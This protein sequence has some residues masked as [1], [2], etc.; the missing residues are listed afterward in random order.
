MKCVSLQR[1]RLT[2]RTTRT[3]SQA[4]RTKKYVCKYLCSW[5]IVRLV[6][7]CFTSCTGRTGRTSRTI[8]V[9]PFTGRICSTVLDKALLGSHALRTKITH[10]VL[11][12]GAFTILERGAYILSSAFRRSCFG[13]P[14]STVYYPIYYPLRRGEGG[15]QL[16]TSCHARSISPQM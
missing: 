8:G 6:N 9:K 16:A 11:C 14:K 7:H 2:S 12:F 5:P 4:L 10:C 13:T 1:L 3:G 15:R